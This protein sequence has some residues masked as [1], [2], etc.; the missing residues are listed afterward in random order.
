MGEI[1]WQIWSINSIWIAVTEVAEKLYV[2]CDEADQTVQQN[3]RRLDSKTKFW[4]VWT[5]SST[6]I[7]FFCRQKPD[8]SWQSELRGTWNFSELVSFT[9]GGAFFLYLCGLSP[10]PVN[11]LVLPNSNCRLTKSRCD[12][13]FHTKWTWKLDVFLFHILRAHDSSYFELM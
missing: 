3:H 13:I 12:F 9:S 1:L 6:K 11:S 4:M 5:I 10:P 8:F 7:R 2:F